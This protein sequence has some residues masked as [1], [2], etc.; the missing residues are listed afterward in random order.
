MLRFR[1]FELVHNGQMSQFVLGNGGRPDLHSNQLSRRCAILKQDLST[2]LVDLGED[3][4]LRQISESNIPRSTNVI[5]QQVVVLGCSAREKRRRPQ[6]S[7]RSYS[8][9][10][11]IETTKARQ[12]LKISKSVWQFHIFKGFFGV[13]NRNCGNRRIV[14]TNAINV[15][16]DLL[17]NFFRFFHDRFQDIGNAMRRHCRNKCLG[18]DYFRSSRGVE[19]RLV[20]VASVVVGFLFDL[21]RFVFQSN[22]LVITDAKFLGNSVR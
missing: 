16:S 1:L 22:L 5:Q 11:R 4:F 13:G 20:I 2:T 19:C 12:V 9:G 15:L 14:D 18:F 3:L 21:C 6:G 17:E 8:L 7:E 10:A